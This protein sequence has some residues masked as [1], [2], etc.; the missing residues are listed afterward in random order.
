[1][2]RDH[3]LAG[4]DLKSK[5]TRAAAIAD[6]GYD[7]RSELLIPFQS[8]MSNLD[9]VSSIVAIHLYGSV[10]LRAWPRVRQ[11]VARFGRAA[12]M[13]RSVL[14]MQGGVVIRVTALIILFVLPGCVKGQI[15]PVPVCANFPG[16]RP[17]RGFDPP[18]ELSQRLISAA[19]HWLVTHGQSPEIMFVALASDATEHEAHVIDESACN[20]EPSLGCP[21]KFCATLVYDADRDAIEQVL[22][23]R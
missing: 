15:R 19:T 17:M 1:M 12:V 11:I 6:E 7:P 14:R 2:F 13:P 5:P 18:D 21:G 23:W 20:A 10:L 8:W 9:D 16:Y 22:Y 4:G 3:H